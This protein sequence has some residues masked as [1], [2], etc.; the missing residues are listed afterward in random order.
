MPDLILASDSYPVDPTGV[1]DSSLGV[2]QA[3]DHLRGAG[4]GR[5][6][7]PLG[8]YRLNGSVTINSVRTAVQID[9]GDLEIVSQDAEDR[10]L[11]FTDEICLLTP[12]APQHTTLFHFHTT[13]QPMET[14]RLTRIALR[15]PAP[16]DA[17]AYPAVKGLQG[18]LVLFHGRPRPGVLSGIRVDDCVFSDPVRFA[19]G[20]AHCEDVDINHC[21][22]NYH[23]THT[24]DSHTPPVSTADLAV[25]VL[26]ETEA[27]QTN[28]NEAGPAEG[29]CIRSRKR[30]LSRFPLPPASAPSG[31]CSFGKG[32]I[33]RSIGR[34]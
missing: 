29:T 34:G 14:V 18:A 23:S 19:I 11:F 21:T 7:V 12:A 2:Q 17:S 30:A 20:L 32:G 24:F 31:L 5:L 33:S 13:T 3:I 8:C 4:G 10:P 22:I 28:G 6:I 9:F 15:G 25:G 16:N 26:S 27:D 1:L